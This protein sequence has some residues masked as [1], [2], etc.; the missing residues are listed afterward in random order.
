MA[1]ARMALRAA[2]VAASFVACL[3]GCSGAGPGE[4]APQNEPLG[5]ASE[6]LTANDQIAF[7]YFL[8]KGL[9]PIQAAG[10]VG[11]LDQESGMDPLS[12]EAG[13]PGRGIAQWSVGGRWDTS[14]NDNAMAFASSEGKSV[15][16]LSLQLDFIWY[17]LTTFPSYGLSSLQS[18]TTVTSAT[19]AFEKDF[20]ACGTCAESKRIQYADAALAAFGNDV[21]G[22]G[23][24]PDAGPSGPS[25][26]VPSL[27]ASGECIST[28]DC[29]TIPG[30]VSTPGYC[31]GAADIQCCTGPS[32]DDAGPPPDNPPP[33]ADDDAATS[34]SSPGSPPSHRGDAGV[35]NAGN[36]KN[37][38]ASGD[39][40]ELAWGADLGNSG[41]CS[42]SRGGVDASGG[43]LAYACAAGVA[44]ML[45]RRR[46]APAP[47]RI[48]ASS[49]RIWRRS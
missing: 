13:G 23:S 39:G 44:F 32:G 15:Q 36:G 19:E 12:V 2:L 35:L 4:E 16:S 30:H 26:F 20:E 31:P 41:G 5:R 38:A 18:A 43:C 37:P 11:N 10:I 47:V 22:A 33:P 8:A 49:T 27:G 48:A 40:G 28:T 45:R 6:A 46:R 14:S 17:E 9:S 7:D 3:N 1:T 21:V 29:A 24:V 34:S 42:A 25:C